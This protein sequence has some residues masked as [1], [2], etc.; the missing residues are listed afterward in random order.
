MA[1]VLVLKL[2]GWWG[3]GRRQLGQCQYTP[4]LVSAL[5]G[6]NVVEVVA[7]HMHSLCVDA[8]GKVYSFGYGRFHQLGRNSDRCESQALPASFPP[9][10]IYARNTHDVR[11]SHTCLED[12]RVSSAPVP[13]DRRNRVQT[14]VGCRPAF[15][16]S[17]CLRGT[18]RSLGG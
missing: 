14:V 13:A 7:G 2:R 3:S 6:L 5:K 8:D 11:V 9:R 12:V 18:M 10:C 16:S 4:R 1:P 15:L 17:L